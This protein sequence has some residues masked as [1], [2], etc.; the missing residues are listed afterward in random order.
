MNCEWYIRNSWICL[1]DE[2]ESLKF[3]LVLTLIHC[4]QVPVAAAVYYE[5][6]YVSF[7]L[8]ME[9][10]S[11]I[12]GIRLWITNE[13]M[14]SGLRDDGNK[15]IDH[16]LGML[17]GKKP[18][19]WSSLPLQACLKTCWEITNGARDVKAIIIS[20]SINLKNYIYDMESMILYIF[21]LPSTTLNA[22][23]PWPLNF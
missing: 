16:L 20:F 21:S 5:D 13:F 2:V 12:S 14:H 17:N 1:W 18:L 4:W 23:P 6:L 7:K 11:Q 22:L 10:A 8:A 15:V 3:L 9:T 19:F